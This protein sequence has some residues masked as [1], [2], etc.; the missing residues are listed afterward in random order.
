[1]HAIA[2]YWDRLPYLVV[3]REFESEVK[4]RA[5]AALFKSTQSSVTQQKQLPE[6]A[7]LPRT[8]TNA[9]IGAVPRTTTGAPIG[10]V[11]RS[12]STQ[13]S[14]ASQQ[15]QVSNRASDLLAG[16]RHLVLPAN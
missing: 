9:P 8:T 6:N 3:C 4:D 13:S 16:S 12:S 5:K 1:M 15:L 14:S 2:M 10:P 11:A 7:S